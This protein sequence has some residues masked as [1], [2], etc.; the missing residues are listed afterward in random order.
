MSRTSA[1][2]FRRGGPAGVGLVMTVLTAL[3]LAA[4]SGG[5]SGGSTPSASA[6]A[7]GSD[8]GP[9]QFWGWVPGL[10]ALVA[11]WNKAHPSI[12]VT[13]HRMTGDDGKKVEA[14]VDAGAGPDAVQLSTHDLPDYVIHKRVVDISSYV[15]STKDLYTPASWNS[16]SFGTGIYGVPQGSG[17]TA[18]MYRKDILDKYGIAIPKTWDEFEAAAAA[19]HKADPSVYLTGFYPS[20]IGQ[21][22]QD[23]SQ[24]GGSY[25]GVQGNSW[26]VKINDAAAQKVA[27]R[28]QRL[29]D[30][31]VVKVSQMWTPEYWADVNAGHLASITYAAWFPVQLMTNCKGLSGKWTVAPQ[32]SY[33]G[34][35]VA[36]DSGGAADVVLHG[37]KNVKGTAEFLTWLNSAKDPVS[38]LIKVGGI[39]PTA[40]VGLDDPALTEKFPYFG[41]QAIYDVFR[42]ATL[43]VPTTW[44]D[45]PASAQ[46]DSDLKD[47]FGKVANGSGTMTQALADAQAKAVARLKSMGLS[48][49]AGS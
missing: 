32:P 16:V 42:Q 10:E 39:F 29:V 23:L 19:L 41:G 26:A 18:T 27:A 45:G 8:A 2:G 34:T 49:T 36:G 1:F 13:F 28:W 43:Q 22:T 15:N 37:A 20:E 4:C 30:A 40:K 46:V 24:A 25:F 33:G 35:P 11:I 47:G 12:P 48:V 3:L 5:S 44:T 31:K 21:W 6:A 14:A 17:P 9:V 7:T 38:A